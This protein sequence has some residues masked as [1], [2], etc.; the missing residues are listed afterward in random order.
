MK[1]A[2]RRIGGQSQWALAAMAGLA[3]MVGL[4][5]AG[6]NAYLSTDPYFGNPERS[7]VVGPPSVNIMHALTEGRAPVPTVTLTPAVVRA[8]LTMDEKDQMALV[9]DP[10]TPE[11]KT[12][13]REIIDRLVVATKSQARTVIKR[14]T[15]LAH[16]DDVSE[17]TEHHHHRAVHHLVEEDGGAHELTPAQERAERLW[18][19][20]FVTF[21]VTASVMFETMK[22][23]I[24][25]NTPETMFVV[26]DKFFGELATLG[27]IGTL[28]FVFTTDI[29]GHTSVLGH[30]SFW[31]LGDEH[32][33]IHEFEIVHFLIF[34]VMIFFVSA[35][36]VILQIA[37]NQKRVWDDY[38]NAHM[39]AVRAG[40]GAAGPEIIEMMSIPDEVLA[41]EGTVTSEYTKSRRVREAEFIRFR[42]RFLQDADCPVQIPSDFSFSGYLTMMSAKILAHIVEIEVYDWAVLWVVFLLIYASNQLLQAIF[43]VLREGLA[44][45]YT[46]CVAFAIL[47]VVLVIFA[48][49]GFRSLAYIRGMLVPG[50]DPKILQA[51]LE[52]KRM[53][54]GNPG[55]VTV[56]NAI[57]ADSAVLAPPYVSEMSLTHKEDGWLHKL[58]SLVGT[59]RQPSKHEQLFGS[60]GSNG[61][62]L[63]MHF[64]KV[65]LLFSVVS[66]AALC[67]ILFDP[68]WELNFILPFVA[69]IPA[70]IAIFLT[71]R[72]VILYVWC[73][74]CEML[75]DPDVVIVVVRKMRHEKLI[76]II[77]IL[78]M[79]S[80]FLDQ[81]EFLKEVAGG[82]ADGDDEAAA[83]AVTDAQ[84]AKLIETTDPKIVEDLESLFV[85]YDDDD[86]GE[87]DQSEV[88]EL[89][90]QLGT[91]LSDSEAKNLF[92]VMDADGSGSVD[93]K[94][95]AMVILH[96]K[97]KGSA[98]INY[99]ELAEK[100][101][102]IFD[103]DNSGIVKQDEILDQ[104]KKMGKNWD[105]EGIAFFLSQIDK[106]GS[107]EIDRHEFVDYI[108]KIEAEVKGG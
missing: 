97:A 95:F 60:L 14:E 43:P 24:I 99:R 52:Q 106:D 58:F 45:L 47:Q 3:A 21:I 39:A 20:I 29:A 51:A 37:V 42:Q 22:E 83:G 66:I 34:F 15:R 55:S 4:M 57:K 2:P 19:L 90:A 30:L 46:I 105:H 91:K 88:K 78:S 77:R 67:V 50:L 48:V 80:F 5:V 85:A 63:F 65:I 103:Q 54:A 76:N 7:T 86:S 96:Q 6:N 94:E 81:V 100:M 26:V 104:M 98:Q 1:Q 32:L 72:M 93:F 36:L 73:C 64:I 28:A 41:V 53:S 79:L 25:H 59:A 102:H 107:G 82:N 16:E 8:L 87:L 40:A 13:Q 108:M 89:V 31:Y 9:V 69:V 33:L 49:L 74:S 56:E 35:V 75:K 12:T 10:T 70:V 11:E 38:E 62:R 101:F 18:A 23:I 71:P 84:W 44:P 92:Q 27:F 68:L 61:P 17:E